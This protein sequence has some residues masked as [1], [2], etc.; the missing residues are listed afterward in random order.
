MK[1]INL[2]SIRVTE[3]ILRPDEEIPLA[4]LYEI[5]DDTGKVVVTKRVQVKKENLPAQ[6]TTAIT[7]LVDRITTRLTTLEGI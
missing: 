6:A 4:V 3:T 5:L 7:N 1:Q 2:T